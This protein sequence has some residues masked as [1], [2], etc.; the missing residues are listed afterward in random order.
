MILFYRIWLK[1]LSIASTK[2]HEKRGGKR[3]TPGE[4]NRLRWLIKIIKS[5]GEQI[6]TVYIWKTAFS[7]PHERSMRR[8]PS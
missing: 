5:I 6:T 3:K 4:R 7:R 2:E 1:T 8:E